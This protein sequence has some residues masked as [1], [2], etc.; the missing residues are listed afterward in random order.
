MK[1]RINLSICATALLLGIQGAELHAHDSDYSGSGQVMLGSKTQTEGE[2]PQFDDLRTLFDSELRKLQESYGDL[3]GDK[4]SSG[5]ASL[6]LRS[7]GA[8][9]NERAGFFPVK[10]PEGTHRNCIAAYDEKV[11]WHID[12]GGG[13]AENGDIAFGKIVQ[14]DLKESEKGIW[15][16]SVD[17]CTWFGSDN[18]YFEIELIQD[19]EGGMRLLTKEHNGDL[20]TQAKETLV[21]DMAKLFLDSRFNYKL[22][23]KGQHMKFLAVYR[24]NQPLPQSDSFFTDPES[25]CFDMF[26]T[27]PPTGRARDDLDNQLNYCMGRC[28]A[29]LLNT[30]R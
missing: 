21:D 28:D 30:G 13:V 12:Y 14:Y 7:A 4:D 23:A 11:K 29:R 6:F 2:V 5:I 1:K 27:H 8:I 22:H 17:V 3:L 15:T 25:Q 20:S 16:G 10:P 19:R 24:N 9:Y 18:Y 26:F